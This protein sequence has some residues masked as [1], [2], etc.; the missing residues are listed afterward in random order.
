MKRKVNFLL[1]IILSAL[2][3]NVPVYAQ[4]A[5]FAQNDMEWEMYSFMTNSSYKML[6]ESGNYSYMKMIPD[7]R[8][9]ILEQYFS[10]MSSRLLQ[11]NAAPDVNDYVY[12]LTNVITLYDKDI[13]QVTAE[14]IKMDKM[15]TMGDYAGDLIELATDIYGVY[16]GLYRDVDSLAQGIET[17]VDAVSLLSDNTE[18]WIE[19]MSNLETIL[20]DYTEYDEFLELIE[21]EG[22]GDLKIAASM[23]RTSMQ[24]AMDIKLKA[25]AELSDKNF[26]NYTEFF[27]N[28]VLYEVAKQTDI[29]E[30]DDLFQFFIDACDS[31][32]NGEFVVFDSFDVGIDIGHLIG[33]IVVGSDNMKSRMLEMEALYDIS[34]ILQSKVIEEASPFIQ[35]YYGEGSNPYT[36]ELINYCNALIACRYRGEYCILNML[37][38]DSGLLSWMNIK[39]F[40]AINEWYK[41]VVNTLSGIKSQIPVISYADDVVSELRFKEK[42]PVRV[43]SAIKG[44][45]YIGDQSYNLSAYWKEE[46]WPA[47]TATGATGILGAFFIDL[48]EDGTD[49]IFSVTYEPSE[50]LSEGNTIHFSVFKLSEKTW[51][52]LTETDIIKQYYDGECIDVSCMNGISAYYEGAICMRKYNG[53]YEF[54]YEDYETGIFATGQSWMFRGFRFENGMLNPMPETESISFEGSPI[55]ILWTETLD[56]VREYMGDSEVLIIQNYCSLGFGRPNIDFGQ[57]TVDQQPYLYPIVRM[58]LDSTTSG[59]G[60]MDWYSNHGQPLKTFWYKI[61]DCTTNIPEEIKEFQ[62]SEDDLNTG[63]YLIADSNTQY[64]EET[65]VSSMSA[66]DIQLAIN[67]IFA[68]HGRIFLTAEYDQYFR[69]KSWYQ[70]DESKTDDQINAEF[71]EYEKAN[72][73]LLSKYQ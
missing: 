26:D 55:D 33:N 67:E 69:S 3:W 18:N 17:A 44:I 56:N 13:A 35:A 51:G 22:E 61:T 4:E 15:N 7:Y 37:V 54:F 19:T 11:E 8:S 34:S 12:A 30:N 31:V 27:F 6:V 70:P 64:L 62:K 36:E 25:Y 52:I 45:P 46:N 65:V 71:N 60:I 14:L 41:S 47:I 66:A 21:M 28:D 49:E 9:N 43:V 63:D 10:E 73:D 20:Q 50:L 16:G 24:N 42:D 48:D 29:Y 39:S 40:D 53:S 2:L 68:R 38:N 58:K 23:M 1:L 72:I 5:I 32:E 57:L 59:D